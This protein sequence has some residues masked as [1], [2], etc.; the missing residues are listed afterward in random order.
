MEGRRERTGRTSL[1]RNDDRFMCVRMVVAILISDG[2][3]AHVSCVR[4]MVI[5]M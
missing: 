3:D 2:V 5:H 1:S 4:A